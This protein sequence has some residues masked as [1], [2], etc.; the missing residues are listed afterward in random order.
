MR[1][2]SDG[3]C[4][5][6]QPPSCQPPNTSRRGQVCGRMCVWAWVLKLHVHVC[7]G[8]GTVLSAGKSCLYSAFLLSFNTRIKGRGFIKGLLTR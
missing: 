5:P 8:E 3:L 6:Q 7:S 1:V 2:M 4:L